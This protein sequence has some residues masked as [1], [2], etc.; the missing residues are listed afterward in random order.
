[1][2]MISGLEIFEQ[3]SQK[4]SK[5]NDFQFDLSKIDYHNQ[6]VNIDE[7]DLRAFEDIRSS[8]MN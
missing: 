7:D 3:S 8:V 5:T 6:S 1:M 2:S 4:S